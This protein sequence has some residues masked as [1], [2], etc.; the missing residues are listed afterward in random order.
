M[1]RI[2]CLILAS[3]SFASAQ[4]TEPTELQRLTAQW[5]KARE[6]ATA[7]ID[8]K[9]LDAL[10]AMKLALTKQGNL[11]GALAVDAR[12]KSLQPTTQGTGVAT[13][14]APTTDLRL[15]RT[16]GDLEKY[17]VGTVWSVSKTIGGTPFSEMSFTT[18]SKVTYQSERDWQVID[19]RSIS[20]IGNVVTFDDNMTS[21][22]V[23][24]GASGDQFGK[25]KSR[26]P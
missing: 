8:K 13:P 20:I 17:L 18:T 2:I 24:W 10:T 4:T 19:K 3:W 12:I 6:Q 14:T 25:L 15:P 1:R 5:Q 7:P 23:K 11:E 9:Y 22:A 26:S 16:K 21:F